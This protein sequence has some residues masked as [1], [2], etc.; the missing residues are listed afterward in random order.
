MNAELMQKLQKK[1]L[2]D[3]ETTTKYNAK[4]AFVPGDRRHTCEIFDSR[5]K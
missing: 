4:A 1:I 5:E 2:S 3:E